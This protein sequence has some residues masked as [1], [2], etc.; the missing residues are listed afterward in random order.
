MSLSLSFIGCRGQDAISDTISIMIRLFMFLVVSALGLS[1]GGRFFKQSF[2]MYL[3]KFLLERAFISVSV[4]CLSVTSAG[5]EMGGT[6]ALCDSG[7]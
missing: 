4:C 6:D 5:R 1:D 2:P 7:E 3:F